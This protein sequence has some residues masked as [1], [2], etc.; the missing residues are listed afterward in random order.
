MLLPLTPLLRIDGICSSILLVLSLEFALELLKSA[1]NAVR[2]LPDGLVV[3]VQPPT[4]LLLLLEYV[5]DVP[6]VK[7]WLRDDTTFSS[8]GRSAVADSLDRLLR[9]AG[10]TRD[11][12]R[13][14]HC[15]N[16]WRCGR[17]CRR[18]KSHAGRSTRT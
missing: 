17:G 5:F 12:A 15:S 11:A 16:R 14:A 13:C 3:L 1:L 4:L 7:L 9:A 2:A 8:R 10:E 18:Q 6:Q